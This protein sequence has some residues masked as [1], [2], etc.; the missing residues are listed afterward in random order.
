MTVYLGSIGPYD[1]KRYLG[2][3][4]SDE[5]LEFF[6]KTHQ[7]CADPYNLGA[8][9]WHFFDLPRILICGSKA[10]ADELIAILRQYETKDQIEVGWYND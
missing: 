5:H 2:F 1:F 8:R 10:L 4:L 9:Q 7:S 3:E 6:I